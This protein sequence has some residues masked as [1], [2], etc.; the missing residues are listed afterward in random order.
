MYRRSPEN[1]ERLTTALA[2]HAPY[3]RGAPPNLPFEW[4]SATLRNGLNIT[5]ITELGAIDLLGRCLDLS[6]LIR[7]KHA[8]GRPKDLE[9]IAELQALAEESDNKSG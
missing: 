9:V 8:A 6:W 4:S 1:L 3:L 7:T 5:L 2:P